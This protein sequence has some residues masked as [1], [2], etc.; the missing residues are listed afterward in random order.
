MLKNFRRTMGPKVRANLSVPSLTATAIINQHYA[1]KRKAAS[2]PALRFHNLKKKFYRIGTGNEPAELND[3]EGD[4]WL[5]EAE[6]ADPIP[7]RPFSASTF[8]IDSPLNLKSSRITEL[9]A[10]TV[11]M[12]SEEQSAKLDVSSIIGRDT[13]EN[14]DFSLSFL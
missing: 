8:R 1:E 13:G 12:D 4:S 10:D 2:R 9:L 5:D 3:V 7:P 11:A 14:N 6:T